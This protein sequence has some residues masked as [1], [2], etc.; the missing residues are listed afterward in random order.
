MAKTHLSLSHMPDKKGTPT[1]FVLPIR[2]VR[3]SVGAG[4]IYP[5]VGT[6]RGLEQFRESGLEQ[7]VETKNMSRIFSFFLKSNLEQVKLHSA[8]QGIIASQFMFCFFKRE[9]QACL[10]VHFSRNVYKCSFMAIYLCIYI[11]LGQ[12]PITNC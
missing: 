10:R 3:A 6:V 5:L 8:L 12:T 11:C 9:P 7:T 2:D 4:F 1:G